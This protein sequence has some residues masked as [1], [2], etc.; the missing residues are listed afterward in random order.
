MLGLEF[1]A[2]PI[3]VY[4]CSSEHIRTFVRHFSG[5]RP[6]LTLRAFTRIESTIILQT[7]LCIQDSDSSLDPTFE[8]GIGGGE[9]EYQ[10]Y[11]RTYLTCSGSAETTD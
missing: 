5:N 4:P 11:F 9:D 6:D 8:V 1:P 3:E 10:R 7:R 2:S